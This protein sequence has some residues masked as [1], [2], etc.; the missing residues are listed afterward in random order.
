V[1][2]A[3]RLRTLGFDVADSALFRGGTEGGDARIMSLNAD[4]EEPWLARDRPV[5]LK[6]VLLVA[7][8][9][10]QPVNDVAARLLELGY[11]LPTDVVFDP[12]STTPSTNPE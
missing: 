7:R 8:E 9:T 1:D 12:R 3:S 10:G 2:V 11:S 4:G 5:P 6:H